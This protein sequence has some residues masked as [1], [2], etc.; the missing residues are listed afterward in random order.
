MKNYVTEKIDDF[1]Y[2]QIKNLRNSGTISPLEEQ[3]YSLEDSI[4][5]LISVIGNLFLI[6]LPLMLISYGVYFVNSKKKDHQK[7]IEILRS[8]KKIEEIQKIVKTHTSQHFPSASLLSETAVKNL[9]RSSASNPTVRIDTNLVNVQ[10]F[11]EKEGKVQATVTF[12]EV[13]G[14][15]I[16]QFLRE[17]YF[18]NK[19]DIPNIDIQRNAKSQLLS[20]KF[21]M[22]GYK[23]D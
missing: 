6:S 7:K 23:V 10:G 20:G 3:Y 11:N 5:K 21:Q 19:F 2:T 22:T 1:F 8:I 16:A 13:N 12:K 14:S 4:Q 15:Q 18:K 9:I 17:L